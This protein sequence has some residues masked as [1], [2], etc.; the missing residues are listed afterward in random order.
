[1]YLFEKRLDI[2]L[3]SFY[4]LNGT[5]DYDGNPD[6]LYVHIIGMWDPHRNHDEGYQDIHSHVRHDVRV[7]DKYVLD[8]RD[9]V[10]KR[11]RRILA[12]DLSSFYVEPPTE[13]V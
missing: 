8:Y 1:M 11:R 9:D 13:D 2:P 12:V 5:E 4:G 10:M 7:D 6:K 3:W